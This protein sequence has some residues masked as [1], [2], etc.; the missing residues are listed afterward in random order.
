[1]NRFKKIWTVALL[2]IIVST[3]NAWDPDAAIAAENY[4]Y[5]R[6][7]SIAQNDGIVK[8]IITLDVP[9]IEELTAAATKYKT[10][11]AAQSYQFARVSADAAL[12]ARIAATTGIVTASLG[13]ASYQVS[14]TYKTLPLL[15]IDASADA[16]E[17]LAS[18]P[19]VLRIT[20]DRL[21]SPVLDNT[22]NIIGANNAWDSGYTGNGWYVAVLDTGIRK[23]HEF[24]S[25][26]TIIEACY[27][28][29]GH[30][31]NN[32]TEMTGSGA[33]VHHPTDHDGWDHGTHVTGIATGKSASLSGVGKDADII[34]IQVFSR[35]T[36]A[37]NC[38][39]GDPCVLS[40]TSDQIKG[41]EYV[42]EQRATYKIAA[43]NMSLGDDKYSN[44][45]F[46]DTDNAHSKTAID[47][48]RN[49]GIATIIASGNDG[50]CDGISA[51]ACV[52]SAIAVGAT[53]D[54]DAEWV[55][56]NWHS[57]LLDLFAPGHSVYSSTAD[58]DSRFESWSG[59]SMA[60]PHVA[61][62][63]AL[64]RQKNPVLS[65]SELLN[66]VSTT[67]V[68][69]TTGC[70]GQSGTKPRVQIDV[71][72]NSVVLFLNATAASTSQIDLTWTD[73]SSNESGFEIERKTGSEG[74][75]SQIATV[76]SNTTSYSDTGLDAF[77][78]FYYR[79][80]AYNSNGNSSYSNE[81]VTATFKF[82]L[83]GGGGG[84]CFIATAAYG[85]PMA[86]QVKLLRQFRDNFLLTN[87]IGKGF[88][89][90]YYTY[91]PP[92][93]DFIA[94]YN[95]LR[96]II[97]LSLLPVVGISWAALKIGPV[98][99]LALLLLLCSVLIG[100]VGFRRK[101]KN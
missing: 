18:I 82:S 85:S 91:S 53:T 69:V 39:A 21:S 46:C 33:A 70:P 90:L 66:A 36:G 89:H 100:L 14:H 67:G 45:S 87:I 42:F 47:N 64:L 8:I 94:K 3:H 49:V 71:A 75:Y 79:V 78:T 96:A 15:A 5:D 86:S 7:L 25:G 16:L 43:V 2:L 28:A 95:S 51:P 92:V 1:M 56:N 37:G 68:E 50:Y 72:L 55:D 59:T 26:K 83:G 58:S 29:D 10:V 65:V 24:F 34:A 101:F 77:V 11:N 99:S 63:W 84:G 48:L 27:S 20:E 61:G 57:E 73:N 76:A 35:F 6:L 30:C 93:A 97:R 38:G 4:D 13:D 40:Y 22:V 19:E 23:T 81:A 31:P 44:Q 41:L 17:D 60:A 62:A 54:D 80:R 98:Y 52:S 88:V 74:T 9:K 12:A 32:L